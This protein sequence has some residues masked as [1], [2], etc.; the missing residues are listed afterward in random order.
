[1]W[2]KHEVFEVKDSDKTFADLIE[3]APKDI[4]VGLSSKNVI[5]LPSHNT[6]D[7]FY[8]GTLDILDYLNEN[9]LSSEIYS[10]DD[11]YKE[12]ALHSSDFW[13]GTFFVTNIVIP[14]FCS[15]VGSYVY[16]KLKGV[17][18]DQISMKIYVEKKDGTTSA[19][20]FKGKVED[21]DKALEVIGKFH[22]KI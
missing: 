1:L 13:L 18:G 5:V 16:A 9:G 19:V 7:E 2:E 8:C 22:E 3:N 10:N 12:L 15:V 21:F 20:D 11:D 17:R 14:V 4:S 6:Q